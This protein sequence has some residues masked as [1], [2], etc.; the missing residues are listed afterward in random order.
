MYAHDGLC[1]AELCQRWPGAASGAAGSADQAQPETSLPE[2]HVGWYGS[3]SSAHSLQ[4]TDVPVLR[5]ACAR[6]LLTWNLKK[7]PQASQVRQYRNILN[8]ILV[9]STGCAS[10]W[11]SC[12]WP[13]ALCASCDDR[14]GARPSLVLCTRVMTSASELRL[15]PLWDL[16]SRA[17]ASV[18]AREF[19]GWLNEA[20]PLQ[21][22][23]NYLLGPDS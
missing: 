19:N 23:S 13:T 12:L 15:L 8:V 16:H 14:P 17:P 21:G 10:Q 7:K 6:P 2:A 18:C 3:Q 4:H 20:M 22:I 11:D 5:Q 1:D 9:I